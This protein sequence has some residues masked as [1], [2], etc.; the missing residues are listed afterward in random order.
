MIVNE[1]ATPPVLTEGTSTGFL[2]K[3]PQ[4]DFQA[5]GSNPIEDIPT[6]SFGFAE[7]L[8]LENKLEYGL[9]YHAFGLMPL[10]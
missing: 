4:N 7:M 3:K 8:M 9:P 10:R 2:R 1:F 5:L 6:I